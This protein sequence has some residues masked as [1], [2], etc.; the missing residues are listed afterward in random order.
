MTHEELEQMSKEQLI[1]YIND[2]KSGKKKADKRNIE[3]E[4]SVCGKKFI[5][6]YA[7]YNKERKPFE[8]VGI[9]LSTKEKA[10]SYTT[11]TKIQRYNLCEECIDELKVWLNGGK[12]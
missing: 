10:G 9:F 4:C 1:D 5:R 2:I 6:H 8:Y 3:L 7:E 12:K 11:K